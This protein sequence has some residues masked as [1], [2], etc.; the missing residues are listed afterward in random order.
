MI[1]PSLE[2]ATTIEGIS[3]FEIAS[4]IFAATPEK[5]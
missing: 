1:R 2:M 3:F 4:W 5:S